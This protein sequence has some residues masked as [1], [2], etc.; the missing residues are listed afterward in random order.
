V[1]PTLTEQAIHLLKLIRQYDKYADD[2][3]RVNREM[4]KIYADYFRA[5]LRELGE[6]VGAATTKL[7]EAEGF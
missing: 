3:V 4:G 2:P 1:K 7:I 6:V 5:R